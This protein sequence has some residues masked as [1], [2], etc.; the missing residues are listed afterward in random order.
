MLRA[1]QVIVLIAV[2]CVGLSLLSQL[3]VFGR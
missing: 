2:V 3:G 1:V